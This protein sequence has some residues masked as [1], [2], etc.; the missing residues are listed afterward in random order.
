MKTSR[1]N[2]R[3]FELFRLFCYNKSTKPGANEAEGFGKGLI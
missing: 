2:H 1:F 3:L